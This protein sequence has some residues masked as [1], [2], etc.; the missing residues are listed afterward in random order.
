MKTTI[1]CSELFKQEEGSPCC[2]KMLRKIESVFSD[3]LEDTKVLPEITEECEISLAFADEDQ[4]EAINEEY[5]DEDGSTDVLS[6][7]MWENE[8]GGFEPPDDWPCL[9]LGDI[10]V[11]KEI[12]AKNA[13][14]NGKSEKDEL[15]LVICHGFLHLIGF[16]HA[17]DAEKE[18]MW[19]EQDKLL[20]SLRKI[21]EQ[22]PEDP[23]IER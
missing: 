12:V 6:F 9:T 22:E 10:I 4:I 5:R 21:S 7:P 19:R 13:E 23:E 16:D 8:E 17:D 2:E 14:E 1:H 15:L 11:C 20:E 3:Y 18:I